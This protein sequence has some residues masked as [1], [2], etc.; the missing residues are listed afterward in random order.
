M[1]NHKKISMLKLIRANIAKY[2]HHI[3]LVAGGEIPRFTY[4]VGI[5]QIISAELIF[6]VCGAVE[7]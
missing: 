1:T 4:T 6:A 5:S 7:L 2:G 3:T